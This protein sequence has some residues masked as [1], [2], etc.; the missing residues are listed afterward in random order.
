MLT[1]EQID[2]L[3]AEPLMGP[4]RLAR[5][6]ELAGATQLQIEE[7]TG[8]RQPQVSAIKNGRYAKLPL[9]T[10][11]RLAAFFG[12]TSDVLFP[13]RREESAAS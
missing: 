4:N 2:T 9:G 13:A 7:A 12:V 11:Q 3:E 6:M 8:V 5:A 1:R 10:A